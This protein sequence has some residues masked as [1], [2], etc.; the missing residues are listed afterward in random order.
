MSEQNGKVCANCRHC[1]RK[2]LS[3]EEHSRVIGCVCEI[4]EHYIGYVE[5][6]EGW[7][8]HWAKE[9]KDERQGIVF[10]Q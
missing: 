8:R 3:E 6:M 5:C 2:V 10:K 7:C 1:I 9:K 4:D